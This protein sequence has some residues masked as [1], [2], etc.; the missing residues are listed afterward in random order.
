MAKL[1]STT[2]PDVN[3]STIKPI[4]DEVAE[5]CSLLSVSAD[6][7]NNTLTLTIDT[8]LVVTLVP[9]SAGTSFASG[10]TIYFYNNSFFSSSVSLGNNCPLRIVYSE[11]FF[12][13]MFKGASKSLLGVLEHF[14]NHKFAKGGSSS[15]DAFLDLVDKN[16]SQ[17][18]RYPQF[19]FVSYEPD[20]I[21]YVSGTFLVTTNNPYTRLATSTVYAI[22][23][24]GMFDKILTINNKDYYLISNNSLIPIDS[25]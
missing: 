14:E 24:M 19:N 22:T 3:L 12:F 17:I 10:T 25:E 5:D 20:T 11:S 9:N 4:F 6:V 23:S 1:I 13:F 15:P 21:D 7:E 8:D 2:L 16:Y 18:K